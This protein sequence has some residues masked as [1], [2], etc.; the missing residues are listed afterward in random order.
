MNLAVQAIAA[1]LAALA[2][3]PAVQTGPLSLNEAVSIAERNA[4]SI[5]LQA[6]NVEINRQRVAQ[7]KSNLGP[8]VNATANYLRYTEEISST[9]G[10]VT[11]ISQP[12][13]SKSAAISATM[14][15]DISGNLH[16]F[17][18]SARRQEDA[19]KLTLE[20]TVN[21]VRLDARTAYFNTLRQERLVQVAQQTVT[22]AEEQLKQARL[23]FDQQ[24]IAMVDVTRFEANL[25]ESQTNLAFAQNNLELAR[26]QFNFTLSRP[27]ETPV[28]LEPVTE[29]PRVDAETQSLVDAASASRPEVR[30]LLLTVEALHLVARAQEINLSPT[31]SVGLQHQRSFGNTG[32]GSESSTFGTLSLNVPLYDSGYTRALVREARQNEEQAKIN[33]EQ[34]R[35]GISQE[36]RSALAD[37]NSARD[38][39]EN[40]EV[41]VKL[42]EEVYRLARVRQDAGA[43]TYV[44]V[45]D[46]ETNL[47]LARNN[48]VSARYDYLTAYAQLQRAV[49]SDSLNPIVTPEP[50]A[51]GASK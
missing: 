3:S 36:V 19:A 46:A 27:I 47:T 32:F 11:V 4:F 12:I 38:R 49:G 34:L 20:A 44:E 39:L 2:T 26:Q 18:K 33:L 22:D 21:D 48:A 45:I 30:S 7:A 25:K 24:Q 28:E 16:R 43:G 5:R 51:S 9:Q 29:L 15:L 40:A 35:L 17:V 8:K 31:L 1:A 23:L 14:P 10:G 6:S 13:D 50:P 42:A 41:Q 37:L